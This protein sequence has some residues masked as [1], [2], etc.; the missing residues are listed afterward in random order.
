V[1]FRN[2]C[3]VCGEDQAGLGSQRCPH[4]DSFVADVSVDEVLGHAGDLLDGH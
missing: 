1:S 4:D 3:P 2:S